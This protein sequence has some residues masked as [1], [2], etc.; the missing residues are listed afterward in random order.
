[1]CLKALKRDA[2]VLKFVKNKTKD[3]CDL[4]IKK[5]GYA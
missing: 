5:S 2:T 4:A 3:M 1:M